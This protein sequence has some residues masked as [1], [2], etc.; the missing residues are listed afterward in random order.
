MIRSMTGFGR[1]EITE[2]SIKATVELKSV[3]HRYLDLNIRI[4]RRLNYLEASV[5]AAVKKNVIR[6]KLDL[7]ISYENAENAALGLKYNRELAEVYVK[8]LREMEEE[9]GIK[10][11][12]SAISLARLPEVISMEEVNEDQDEI[13]KHIEPVLLDALAQFNN[14]RAREGEALRNDLIGKLDEMA[15]NVKIIKERYP[16]ILAEYEKKIREKLSEILA[17]NTI[18]ESRIASEMVIFADRLCTDE[19]I[20]R[21]SNHITTMKDLLIKGGEAGKQLDFI[22]QEMNREAN[23]ILS[24]SNDMR[25][26]GAGIA[27]KTGIEKIR[28][29]IQN[30]E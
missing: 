17:D 1:S 6:G 27:L 14:S 7:Y 28:E 18:D 20:V 9:F 25:T 15:W 16:E 11:D 2:G 21:L 10:G 26:S 22:A 19:E 8:Y 12:M 4:P 5:R 23:T 30:I 24:K 13:W 29:Q 3:N